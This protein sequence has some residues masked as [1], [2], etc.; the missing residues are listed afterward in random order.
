MTGKYTG[1]VSVPADIVPLMYDKSYSFSVI[2]LARGSRRL[3]EA[4]FLSERSEGAFEISTPPPFSHQSIRKGLI[5]EREVVLSSISLGN[6]N[7]ANDE[8]LYH[9]S[10]KVALSIC[11]I[12]IGSFSGVSTAVNIPE[13]RM[14]FFRS[15]FVIRN[16]LAL[17]ISIQIRM[18]QYDSRTRNGN[19]SVLDKSSPRKRDQALSRKHTSY[20]D[21]EDLGVLDCGQSV[22]WTGAVSTDRVQL[23]VRFVGLDGDNSRRFPG[24]S[25]VV[26]IPTKDEGGP[27]LSVSGNAFAHLRVSDAD[28]VP[29]DLSVALETGNSTS[30]VDPDNIRL[31]SETFSSATRVVSIFVPYWIVDSTNEDLEFFAGAPVAG[32]LDKRVQIDGRGS[33]EGQNGTTLGLA[34]LLDNENFLNLPSRSPF[35]V[36]MIGDR[37]SARMTVRK[38]VPRQSR[39]F[40]W[41]HTSPWSDPVPLQAEQNSQHDTTVLSYEESAKADSNDQGR[42]DRFVLRS[43]IM[44]APESFG[45]HLGT[46]LIHIVNRYAIINEIGRDIEIMSDNDNGNS[47]LLRAA[48]RPQPFHFDDSK[49]IRF[50]FKEFG[51]NWSGK[52]NI[53]MN[54]REVTMRLRHK[55][56]VDTVIVTVEVR[57][58]EKSSTCLLIFRQTSRPPFRLENHTM[59]PLQFGQSSTRAALEESDVDAMLLP[60]Q[61]ADFAWGKYCWKCDT[62]VSWKCL[63]F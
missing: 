18:K 56:K 13:Q 44:K 63:T 54:R 57:V 25:S 19:V 40:V 8:Y 49:P 61:N 43:S 20:M 29:L 62:L 48:S 55:M 2:A 32:Q 27:T 60:Y 11:S 30:D 21:W 42:F 52:F 38:R 37:T 6:D 59:Y 51:W 22:N 28:D 23:R 53:R 3:Y 12:R 45:G 35:D 58:E 7:F 24:W 16:F 17:P 50:R 36:M 14:I 9:S 33:G 41:R 39:R 1:F 47:F 31:F 5:D 15:P 26:S 10:E 4:E 46:T 34:E